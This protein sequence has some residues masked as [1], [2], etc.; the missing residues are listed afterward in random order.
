MAICLALAEMAERAGGFERDLIVAIFDAEEPPYFQSY[1]MG[2]IR[3]GED[4]LDERGVH[5]ALIY[6]LVG[7]DLPMPFFRDLAFVT[8][9]ESHPELPGILEKLPLPRKLRMIATLNEYVGDMSDHGVFREKGVPYLFFSCGRW[10]HYHM[11]T[12]TPDRLNYAK[13][14]RL[15]LL[16][17][18][19][20]SSVDK[21]EL[22]PPA[23]RGDDS[24]EFE[25]KTFRKSTGAFYPWLCRWAG[26]KDLET[27]LSMDRMVAKLLSL[28]L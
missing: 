15:A 10:K 5:F 3:F 1:G 22:T 4:E 18:K 9:A 11:P 14:A 12:D 28:G 25:A 19:I 13:M 17:S 23:W 7:H 2:S 8:G 20:L 24:L 27:R 26:V 16:S 6:D 21:T